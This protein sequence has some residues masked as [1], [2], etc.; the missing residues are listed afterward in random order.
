MSHP[1]SADREAQLDA[2]LAQL[3]LVEAELE[4]LG[5]WLEQPAPS[6][7]RD[8][9]KIYAGLPFEQWLQHEFLPQARSRIR[10]NNLPASSMV[11][12]MAMRQYDYH[13]FV[14]E[15]LPLVQLLHDFDKLVVRAAGNG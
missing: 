13:S 8:P 14:E 5:W 7:P 4:R 3:D 9:S 12:V 1:L 2:M 6:S 15:A 11:G 10:D